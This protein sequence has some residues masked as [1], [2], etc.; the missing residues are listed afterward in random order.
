MDARRLSDFARKH[1]FTVV[2]SLSGLIFALCLM[3]SIG[4]ALG[5]LYILPVVLA[6]LWSSSRHYFGIVVTA[7]LT[8]IALTFVLFRSP[9]WTNKLIAVT[10]YVIPLLTIWAITFLSM[11][12]KWVQHKAQLSRTFAVCASCRKVKAQHGWSFDLYLQQPPGTLLRLDLCP[13]CSSKF[14]VDFQGR[15]AADDGTVAELMPA[16]ASVQMKPTND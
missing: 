6:A 4:W 12:R 7:T 8:S 5:G 1:L 14:G 9:H 16:Q 13:G 10:C 11:L 2:L 3:S 15:G